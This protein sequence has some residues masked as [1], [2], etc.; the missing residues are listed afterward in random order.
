MIENVILALAALVAALLFS[1]WLRKQNERVLVRSALDGAYYL[2]R[3]IPDSQ[4]TADMLAELNRRLLLVISAAER[5]GRHPA[6]IR[7]LRDRY[8]PMNLSEAVVERGMTSYTIDKGSQVSLC[9]RSRDARDR[10]YDL[11]LLTMVL[12]HEAAHIASVEV[13]HGPEFMENYKYLLDLARNLSFYVPRDEQT[14]YCGM[15]LRGV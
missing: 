6:A 7:R 1:Y 12:V 5:D 3:N 13:G 11:S 15:M 4:R 14:T 10:L 2:V 8:D 9:V